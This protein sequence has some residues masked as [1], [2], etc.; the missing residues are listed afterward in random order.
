MA[1]CSEPKLKDLNPLSR[2]GYYDA[3]S[4][5]CMN[6]PFHHFRKYFSVR[7]NVGAQMELGMTALISDSSL[8]TLHRT[9][10][11]SMYTALL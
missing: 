6:I 4:G 11:F 1:L 5:D 2:R 3:V 10:Y 9:N 7:V 8:P